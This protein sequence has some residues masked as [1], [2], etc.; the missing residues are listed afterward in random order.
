MVEIPLSGKKANGAVA[1]TDPGDEQRVREAGPWNLHSGGYAVAK[2]RVD[3]KWT[4]MKMHRLVMGIENNPDI[5][6][7]HL[8]ND[9]LNN[10]KSNLLLGLRASKAFRRLQRMR[11]GHQAGRSSRFRGVHWNKDKEKWQVRMVD[12]HGHNRSLG[13]FSDE[14]EASAVY[15]HKWNGE[16]ARL[17]D[18]VKREVEKYF[19]RLEQERVLMAAEDFDVGKA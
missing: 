12:E 15:E 7:D 19:A 8:D 6:V 5:E 13:Y 2:R 1:I 4:T 17:E 14:E 3:G 10:R 16:V 18:V 11:Q 9:P